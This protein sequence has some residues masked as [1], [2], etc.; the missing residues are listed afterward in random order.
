[1]WVEGVKALGEKRVLAAWQRRKLLHIF[2]GPIFI[3]TWPLFTDSSNG[4]I[5]AS[6]VPLAMTVK[7]SLIGLGLIKDEEAVATVS[8]TGDKRELLVGPLLYG[9][10]FVSATLLFWKQA[11]AVICLFVLCFGDGFAEIGG[12][13]YGATNRWSHSPSKS[14]AGSISFVVASFFSIAAFYLIWT[15]MMTKQPF[16]LHSLLVSSSIVSLLLLLNHYHLSLS[17]MRLSSWVPS[18]RI[19]CF[20]DY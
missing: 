8:R 1:L 13:K 10:I 2:T 5:W 3:F 18:M 16:T 4:A 17:T 20:L 6:L 9:L 19:V 12:R 7:F 11:R 15:V 14:M